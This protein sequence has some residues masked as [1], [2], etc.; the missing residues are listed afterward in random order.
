MP[1][2][3]YTLGDVVAEQQRSN[4][5]LGAILAKVSAV[6]NVTVVAGNAPP[7][8]IGPLEIKD[9]VVGKTRALQGFDPD[10]DPIVWS[11]DQSNL[12]TISP[13]GV[14]TFVAPGTGAITVHLDDGKA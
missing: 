8:F 5:L 12:A 2:L 14:L 9:G 3:R 13:S 1:T 7:Q 4:E 11:M 10:G 6:I